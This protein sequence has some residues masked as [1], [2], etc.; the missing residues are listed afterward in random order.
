MFL[1]YTKF[2]QFWTVSAL[3]N[4]DKNMVVIIKAKEVLIRRLVFFKLLLNLIELL[5]TLYR[6]TYIKIIKEIVA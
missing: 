5:I 3:K 6:I 1:K 4:D 2:L